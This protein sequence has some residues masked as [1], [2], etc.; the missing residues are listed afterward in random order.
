MKH[1][2][3]LS[4]GVAALAMIFSACE[5]EPVYGTIALSSQEEIF[6]GI[7]KTIQLQTNT[8]EDFAGDDLVWFSTDES[9]CTVSKGGEVKGISAGE[10][11]V[12]VTKDGTKLNSYKVT[13]YNSKNVLKIN[14][15]TYPLAYA[16]YN[17]S[18]YYGQMAFSSVKFGETGPSYDTMPLFVILLDDNDLWDN[19]INLNT[20]SGVS[21]CV[22]STYS[23][24][25]YCTSNS[26]IAE[27]S[28]NISIDWETIPLPT[29]V[30]NISYTDNYDNTVEIH[31]TGSFDSNNDWDWF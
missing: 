7:G 3:I 1:L 19:D 15:K 12:I 21:F 17:S 30:I 11:I 20:T 2:S 27:G 22:C 25:M 4:I 18:S 24:Y 6:L 31:Y 5:K 10:A 23:D 14:G 13:V 29:A 16:C 28:M 26:S 8:P 9:I